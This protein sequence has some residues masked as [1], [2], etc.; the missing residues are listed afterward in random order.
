MMVWSIEI[1]VLG[2]ERFSSSALHMMD[3]RKRLR[4]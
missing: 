1:G 4:D 3:V 2:W